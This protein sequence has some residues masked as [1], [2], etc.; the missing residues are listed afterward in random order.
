MTD[1]HATEARTCVC[2]NLGAH[3]PCTAP[4]TQEDL[5]CDPCRQGCWSAAR[6]IP[7]NPDDFSGTGWRHT[8]LRFQPGQFTITANPR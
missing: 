6:P 1:H 7:D 4:P 5:R 3:I 2:T 8:T